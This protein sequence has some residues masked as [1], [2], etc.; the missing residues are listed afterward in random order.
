[1]QR[2]FKIKNKLSFSPNRTSENVF[3][4][5]ARISKKTSHI[6]HK[7]ALNSNSENYRHFSQ[8]A[9]KPKNMGHKL[10]SGAHKINSKETY[11][12][13]EKVHR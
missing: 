8:S 12:P 2:D 5:R 4:M 3:T 13:N 11:L 1:M 9:R 7:L 6:N 10:F